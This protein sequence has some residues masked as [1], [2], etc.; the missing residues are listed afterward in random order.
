MRMSLI[1]YQTVCINQDFFPQVQEK[2]NQ[3]SWFKQKPSEG[4][5]FV[6]YLGHPW[7]DSCVS[8][9]E[10]ADCHLPDF[11]SFLGLAPLSPVAWASFLQLEEKE[12]GCWY[13]QASILQLEVKEENDLPKCQYAESVLRK[14]TMWTVG[15]TC[16]FPG[17]DHRVTQRRGHPYRLPY[18]APAGSAGQPHQNHT[19]QEGQE[20]LPKGR[21]VELLGDWGQAIGQTGASLS[22]SIKGAGQWLAIWEKSYE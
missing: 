5:Y 22:P 10:E 16:P 12:G 3:S 6:K 2:E 7:G 9:S 20:L 21:E 13:C 15:V 1:Y 14:D 11:A 18:R 4:I 19:G 8:D 17:H